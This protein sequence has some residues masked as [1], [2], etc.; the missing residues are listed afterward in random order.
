[1]APWVQRER[2]TH[3]HTNT[4]SER[5]QERETDTKREREIF[6]AKWANALAKQFLI[7]LELAQHHLGIIEIFIS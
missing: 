7:A 5:E 3:T 1:M 2:D 4:D 6:I